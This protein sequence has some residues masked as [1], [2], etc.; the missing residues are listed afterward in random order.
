M[1]VNLRKKI[2]IEYFTS[3]NFITI[4]AIQLTLTS[5]A[6]SRIRLVLARAVAISFPPLTSFSSLQPGNGALA[7]G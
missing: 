2:L 6:L 4:D 7:A 5:Q 3:F 1:K